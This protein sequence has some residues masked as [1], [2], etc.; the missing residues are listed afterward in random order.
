MKF[1][2]LLAGTAV[3]APMGNDFILPYLIAKKLNYVKPSYNMPNINFNPID[4]TN[5][6]LIKDLI[7]PA[8]MASAFAGTANE[9]THWYMYMKKNH[10]GDLTAIK[11]LVPIVMLEAQKTP[12]EQKPFVRGAP[13]DMVPAGYEG[14]TFKAFE[15]WG[16]G[17][18][19]FDSAEFPGK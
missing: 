5:K 2:L 10:P 15:S 6:E 7:V 17:D 4:A 8:H 1:S 12:V 19:F 13:V 11:N 14:N 3:A 9:A 16:N 18:G